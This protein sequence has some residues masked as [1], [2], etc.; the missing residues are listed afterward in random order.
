MYTKHIIRNQI[1]RIIV[2][3]KISLKIT[4][5]VV[6]TGERQRNHNDRINIDKIDNRSNATKTRYPYRLIMNNFT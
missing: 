5:I 2:N 6:L 4:D 3:K 1:I